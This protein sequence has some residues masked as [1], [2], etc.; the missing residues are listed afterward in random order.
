[1][2][3]LLVLM[4]GTIFPTMATETAIPIANTEEIIV[5]EQNFNGLT[6][7]PTGWNALTGDWSVSDGKLHQS[8][9]SDVDAVFTD[10]PAMLTFGEDLAY[11]ENFRFETNLQFKPSLLPYSYIGLGFDMH[12]QNPLTAA[13]PL[14][15]AGFYYQT[16][17]LEGL[18]VYFGGYT[19]NSAYPDFSFPSGAGP[20]DMSDGE[21][22][23][24]TIEVYGE[25]GDIYF[26]DVLVVANA[27]IPR[28]EDG[29][30][31]LI[32]G[33]G[34]AGSYDDIKITALPYRLPSINTETL[35]DGVVGLPYLQ[36]LVTYGDK[37]TLS[38]TDGTLPSGLSL[39]S[40][41]VISGTPTDSGIS[42]FTVKAENAKGDDSK[43][44]SITVTQ[45][46][47]SS[48][49]GIGTDF[50]SGTIELVSTMKLPA[51]P[52][53]FEAWVKIPTSSQNVGVITGNGA[54]DGF[55]GL[56]TINFG[57]T[58]D[59]NPW[60][61]WKEGNG[62]VA[63][64]V[65]YANVKLGDW[66]HI[67]IVQ[68]N[69]N[70]R[71]TCYI[72]GNK[73]DEQTFSIMENTIPIRPLKIGG[74][75]L[76]NNPRCFPGEIADIRIW[77]IIRTQTEIQE[78]MN[79]PINGNAAG[80]MVN[81]WLDESNGIYK[82]HSTQGNDAQIWHDWLA[83]EFAEGDYTIAVVP[84]IQNL[85]RYYPDVLDTMI[86]WIQNNAEA[87]NIKFMIQVGD[88]TDTNSVE[89][90][91]RVQYNF[92]KLDGVVPYAFIPGNHDYNGLITN[93]DT[94]LFNTYF[95]YNTYSQTPIF[96]GVY[97]EGKLDNAYYYFTADDTDYMLLCLEMAPR[98]FVL[99]WANEVVASNT[100]R[101]VIVV[102]HS[103]LSYNG[104]YDNS[105][106]YDPTGN[107]G[108][109]IWDKFV[110]QHANIIMVLCG[111]I[112]YDDLVMR[113]DTNM[114]GNEVPQ[115]LTDAQ[116][117]DFYREGVGMIALLTF[118]NNGHDIT[119]NW[120]S[121]KNDALFRE[122]N[123]FSFSVAMNTDTV[124]FDSV[125]AS[126]FVTKLNGNKNDLTITVTE[127]YSDATTKIIKETFSINNNAAGI[128][129]VGS[130]KVYVDTKG[131][132]QI[133]ACYIVD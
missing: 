130:Y 118:S 131:N 77:S 80:L 48:F 121:T 107:S 45:K 65:A 94:D 4:P 18:G 42:A 21:L 78:N 35:L 114:Y 76:E 25:Y 68:D 111:H 5:L 91:E 81:W 71:I 27:K 6:E 109:A 33:L 3:L 100:D 88:L 108:D 102:T 23:H 86:D 66:V 60:L 106:G 32:T 101:Y 125:T 20:K 49:T 128:Y 83:P 39:S 61:C 16:T 120:Y 46:Y 96:G 24:I 62:N 99:D 38:I 103:Y 40:N 64:Y 90:W 117:M 26:D 93:R 34:G 8:Y 82:D 79:T 123:Q 70:H 41:G 22:V 9:T 129:D 47:L 112:H 104:E 17:F 133:R 50:S 132:D 51:T 98:N 105:S 73:A 15:Y 127:L 55:N 1:M 37:V 116:D 59:G 92:A 12:Y 110:S 54:I 43:E 113:I 95:P 53:T 19:P 36:K 85:S 52:K 89:E 124:T 69:E 14:M 10:L 115:L 122:W 87:R 30:F 119:V 57:V 7:L 97:E 67:A 84:D 75:Y 44:L 126:A 29:S 31:G 74:D 63:D 2:S 13:G 11:L 28:Y 56:Y 58:A 72:N